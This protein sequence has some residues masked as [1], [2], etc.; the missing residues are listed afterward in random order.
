MPGDR[1]EHYQLEGPG[2]GE[3][4]G[5]DIRFCRVST[6]ICERTTGSW[7]AFSEPTDTDRGESRVWA[8]LVEEGDTW[9]ELSYYSISV[10]ADG[11]AVVQ[12]LFS[13]TARG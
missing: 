4:L 6:V 2:P 3:L 5:D 13:E 7:V 8:T 12:L 9:L 10:S 11:T 1:P